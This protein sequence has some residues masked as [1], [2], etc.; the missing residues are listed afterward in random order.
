MPIEP[1]KNRQS[2]A[3]KTFGES[4]EQLA[5][6]WEILRRLAAAI[7]DPVARA[8]FLE[9]SRTRFQEQT[10]VRP[11]DDGCEYVMVDHGHPLIDPAQWDGVP[12]PERQWVVPDWLPVGHAAYLTGAGGTGKSL[13]GQVLCTCL[14]T[15]R[16]FM[17]IDVAPR[18]VLYLTCEDDR[19]ELHRRQAAICAGLEVSMAELSGKL[20]LSSCFGEIDNAAVAFD[21]DGTMTATDAWIRLCRVI[22]DNEIDVVVLDNVAHLFAGNEIIRAQVTAFVSLLGRLA[23]RIGGSVLLIGHPNKN[24]DEY[25]GSTAWENA[26]RARLYLKAHMEGDKIGDPFKRE[27]VRAKSNYAAKGANLTLRWHDGTFLLAGNEPPSVRAQ[28]REVSTANHEN[29][30]FLECLRQRAAE[31]DGRAVGPSP[32]PNYAPTQFEGMAP[33]RGFKRVALKR[34][35]DRLFALKLIESVPIENP[36]SGRTAHV[37][38]EVQDISHNCL[39]NSAQHSRTTPHNPQHNAAQPSTTHTPSPTER[40]GGADS[41]GPPDPSE[42]PAAT[43]DDL[44]WSAGDGEP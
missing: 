44:D 10:G 18:K 20:F 15:G 29:D 19:D 17:G 37:V 2:N 6:S 32:G 42:W 8:A 41:P 23:Q 38:R 16:D 28:L 5:A 11:T 12:A 39:H 3:L 25:S 9:D 4:P 43:D 21:R 30:A 35:M 7:E 36:K 13:L 14:A 27:L 31:G 34:A 26:F 24:G 22:D 40:S 1:I 33:A